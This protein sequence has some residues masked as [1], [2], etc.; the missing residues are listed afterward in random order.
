MRR[1]ARRYRAGPRFPAAAR[2]LE[3]PAERGRE[4]NAPPH[5]E[6]PAHLWVRRTYAPTARAGR[7]PARQRQSAANRLR[8]RRPNERVRRAGERGAP[9]RQ[10]AG[11]CRFR[12]W[13]R[14]S[15]PAASRGAA[16]LRIGSTSTRPSP[17][18]ERRV[19]LMPAASSRSSEPKTAECSIALETTCAG[20][21]AAC[22]TP[23]IARL[24]DSVP[25]DVNVISLA[26]TPRDVATRCRASSSS[27]RALRPSAC[28]ELGLKSLSAS[29]AR[30]ASAASARSGVVAE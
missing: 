19:V 20:R 10:S 8:P 28:N 5:V 23:A 29:M 13:R 22:I 24:S 14:L 27:A 25:P 1:L 2:T 18:T 6:E 15:W 4:R 17:S 12:C 9:V 26:A 21:G 30:I 3:R 16:R 7:P 11:P